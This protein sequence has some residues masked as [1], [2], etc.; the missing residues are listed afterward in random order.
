MDGN[1]LG[2]LISARREPC[3]IR[4]RMGVL[5]QDRSH[6]GGFGL[7]SA[8]SSTATPERPLAIAPFITGE[9]SQR[10]CQGCSDTVLRGPGMRMEQDYADD[11]RGLLS[12]RSAHSAP[13]NHSVLT[14]REA[15]PGGVGQEDG[16]CR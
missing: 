13:D 8:W 5:L 15:H 12:V 6:E 14:Y 16:G 10:D 4:I 11:V 9:L 7:M 2:G 1:R 3:R